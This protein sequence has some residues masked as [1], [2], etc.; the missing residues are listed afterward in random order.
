MSNKFNPEV[1]WFPRAAENLPDKDVPVLEAIQ[2]IKAGGYHHRITQIRAKFARALERTEGDR[3]A[4]KKAVDAMKK[5]LPAV[6]FSGKFGIRSKTSL[7]T[8]SG[9]LCADLDN[10]GD[11]MA[12]VRSN[13]A[14]DEHL[15]ALFTSPTGD[16]LKAVYRIPVCKTEAQHKAAFHTVSGR[17]KEK[18]AFDVDNTPDW[19]RL[20]FVS[21]DP[22]T[23]INPMATELPVPFDSSP[24]P[25]PDD[26]GQTAKSSSAGP[27][28]QAKIERIV[29]QVNWENQTC[30]Y[31]RCPGEHK[32]TNQN[33]ERDCR[34]KLGNEGNWYL[35]CVHTSCQDAIR[36]KNRE[37]RNG[38]DELPP[39][40]SAATLVAD[41]SNTN[42]PPEVIHGVLHQGSKAILGSSSK[43]RKTWVLLDLGLSV[44]NGVPFRNWNTTKGRVCYI[45]FEIQV[46]FIVGRLTKVAMA[47]ENTGLEN[48]DIWNLRGHA[49]SFD[50]LLPKLIQQLRDK[51]YSLVIIDPVYKGLGGRDENAAGDISELCNEIEKVAV[52]TGAAVVFAAHYS[53]GNQ[54]GREALDR[55]SG[56]GV[57]ARDADTIITLTKHELE[58]CMSVD[59]ILRN[60]PEQPPFVVSWAFPLMRIESALNPEDLK[61]AGG[62]K[63]SHTAEEVWQ[64]L[65][66]RGELTTTEWKNACLDELGLSERTF[67]DRKRELLKLARIEEVANR[68]WR[69]EQPKFWFGPSSELA[70]IRAAAAATTANSSCAVE[71]PGTTATAKP[72]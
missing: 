47:K 62:K 52:Q 36:A 35:H 44:A 34:V 7:K 18:A 4:A 69:T 31:C 71:A 5:L 39:I 14:A 1:S 15:F 53:K 13:L 43:A 48:F 38:V 37:L 59:T 29:G 33:G 54:A 64:V 65:N 3:K 28:E 26:L 41:S 30:G 19:D 72:L 10:L 11:K 42:P 56:S 22:E 12:S 68:K 51:G 16:G 58:G 45:N 9:L 32:H 50:K 70:K 27:G 49:A 24:K 66:K 23:I 60:F 21:F 6:T 61:K 40:V 57:F 8:H 67:Y 17:I 25:G 55:I 20:C 2:L 46:P 63:R